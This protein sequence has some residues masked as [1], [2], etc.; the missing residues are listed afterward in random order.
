MMK[1][2]LLLALTLPHLS[3]YCSPSSRLVPFLPSGPYRNTALLSGERPSASRMPAAKA[4]PNSPE[5]RSPFCSAFVFVY[6]C[7]FSSFCCSSCLP[8]P[9]GTCGLRVF[10]NSVLITKNIKDLFYSFLYVCA[11]RD[12][13]MRTFTHACR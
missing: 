8:L 13:H 6:V 1:L 9:S 3:S 4:M 11:L 12:T 10:S 2:S 5:F 7:A